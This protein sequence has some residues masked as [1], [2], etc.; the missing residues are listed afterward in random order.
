MLHVHRAE[1]TGELASRLAEVLTA[2]PPD[3]FTRDIV[4]V[5]TKGVERWLA[6]RLSHALGTDAGDGVCANV[7]FP[8]PTALL[9]EAL[10]AGSGVSP[11]DDP[12][13]VGRS[14]WTLLGV[15]DDCRREPWC[16][17]LAAHLGDGSGRAPGRRLTTAQRLARLFHSYA[18]SRPQTLRG[19]ADGE[20]T[21]GAGGALAVDLAWQP[22]LW[23]RLRAAIGTHSLAERVPG[24]CRVLREHP[25][26]VDLPERVSVFG[27]TRL[28][29]VELD[30][31]AALGAHRD[32]HL[33]L[34]HP[35]PA[36]WARLDGCDAVSQRRRDD[37]SGDGT[38]NPLLDSLGR[39][40]R[41]LQLRL[42]ASA[43]PRTDE[44]LPAA[45]PP[46]ATLLHR[47]QQAIRAD[48]EPATPTPLAAGDRSVQVHACHGPARQVEVLREVLVG[49]LADDPSLEPRDVLVMCPNIEDYAPLVTATFGLA[50]ATGSIDTHP[51]HR[52]RAR[53]ADRSL[54]QT[55]P[56][57][58][59]VAALLD[60]ADGRVTASEVLDLAA[61]AP[62]RRKFGFGDDDLDLLQSWVATSG[63]R[64][65]LDAE[66]RA[67]FRLQR[68]PQNTWQ[69]GLDRILLG[70]AMAEEGLRWVDRAL[71]LDDVD[72]NDVDLA[73]RLAELIA[74]LRHVLDALTGDRPLADWLDTLTGALD[75]LGEVG[76]ADAWQH[77]QVHRE[78]ADIRDDAGAQATSTALSLGDVRALL[79]DRLAGRPTRA[80]FRTGNL[81]MCS[82]LPMRSVPHR[83]ICLLGLDDGAFPRHSGVDGDDVLARDPCLGE[84]DPRSEDRQ[85]LL[86]ALLAARDHL[87]ILYTGADP[88][89]NVVR[90]PAVP[91]G[92]I[93][94]A[95]D[96]VAVA[97]D[98]RPARTLVV[99]RHPLQPF[100]PRNFI[101]GALTADRPF[102]F[103]TVALGGADRGSRPR[104]PPTAFL[105]APLPADDQG[106]DVEL[107]ELIAWVEHPCR[108][109]LRQRLAV[110]TL[111]EQEA[112]ADSI[113]VDLDGLQQWGIGDRLLQSRLCGADVDRCRQAE[114][115]RGALPP[116][117]LGTRTL[118]ALIA[119]VEPLV[120]A[121]LPLLETE[122]RA[123]DAVADLD[124]RR[125]VG[126]VGDV[127]DG[128]VV[129][130]VFS[131]LGPKHRLRAWLQLLALTV[132]QPDTAWTA[133]TVGRAE[134][135][136]SAAR[137]QL[138]PVDPARARRVLTDI[139]GLRAVGLCRPLPLAT[140]TSATYALA[141][142]KGVSEANALAKA[143]QE[144]AGKFP[145]NDD[146]AHR[147]VWGER[148][149][150][151]ALC[152]AAADGGT[153]EET[154]LFGQLARR[155]W[156]PLLDAEARDVL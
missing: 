14:T 59:L 70:A 38:S 113:A 91:V 108:G 67:P 23:R 61:L 114:W 79:R 43:G 62:V 30:L 154:T 66:H 41:E 24:A 32:V 142:A 124:T 75:L 34:P 120:V 116:G 95:L 27:P 141:R 127:H 82:M 50:D 52:L 19:W 100:D 81:T 144:W 26:R 130:A 80:N 109:F 76:D 40:V 94:D 57:L 146:D 99:T 9:S 155:L 15:I 20:D 53:L 31:L 86:D 83:V 49:L 121:T 7:V 118:D 22:Q 105:T 73:G 134:S 3:P 106:G 54:R 29:S 89:T 128:V 111:R 150:L 133:V 93:L 112:V 92:E 4:A 60:L 6:Q 88:R 147:L 97:A 39:D 129:R 107:E 117:A 10:A 11:E 137:S 101:A 64:W 136:G 68:V 44:H 152:E 131:R 46:G 8:S 55:N 37:T 16:T 17:P 138:G 1:R 149:A 5:P 42:Q 96:A 135:N 87:V 71:P 104:V 84:R 51:G 65:G 21:D 13:S 132:A 35:S 56:M 102:S 45:L 25:E 115:R 69:A 110:T 148:A 140:K 122:G 125:V 47:I 28:T 153:G 143:R 90:P 63:V 48:A 156:Q 98:G 72:S 119:Q 123:V 77:G 85:L 145:E 78:L 58:G 12:W 103:D 151:D 74:R 2:T 33:W 139:V 36:L 18:V 126:T